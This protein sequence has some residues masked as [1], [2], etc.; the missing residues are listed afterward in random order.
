MKKLI[1]ILLTFTTVAALG[2]P[3]F[4]SDAEA[5]TP[6]V[7][8][9]EILD[10]IQSDELGENP[11]NGDYIIV[12]DEEDLKHIFTDEEIEEIRKQEALSVFSVV[13]ENAFTGLVGLAMLPFVPV[14]LIIPVFGWVTSSVA[15]A[16]PFVLI[17]IP[18]Q[19]IGACIES[20]DAYVNF[21]DGIYRE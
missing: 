19:F 11:E 10:I 20:V 7:T 1:A 6:Q 13:K 17:T 21:D 18:F 2:I 4:A 12:E 5:E 9:A 16:S 14:M 3:A 15:I 8:E